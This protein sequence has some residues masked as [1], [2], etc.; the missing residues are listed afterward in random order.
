MTRVGAL[1]T[2]LAVGALA[3]CTGTGSGPKDPISSTP[4]GSASIVMRDRSN[5]AAIVPSGNAWLLLG[6]ADGWRTVHSITPA[7]VPTGGGLALDDRT[8]LTAVGVGPY[9]RLV[10]SPVLTS[11]DPANGWTPTELPAGLA[12]SQHAVAVDVDAVTAVTATAGGTLLRLTKGQWQQVT[13]A[14]DLDATH[15]LVLDS[16]VWA[17][18]GTGWLTGHATGGAPVAFG[19]HDD[20]RSWT[21]VGSAPA[22]AVSALA[23]CGS[24]NDWQLPFLGADL[25]I[26]VS[27]ST[28]LGR[29]WKLGAAIPTGSRTPAWTCRGT[30]SWLLQAADG[31][32]S[33][34]TSD[35]AGTTWVSTGSAPSDVTGLAMTG[36]DTGYAVGK[37]TSG[38]E[39]WTVTSSAPPRFVPVALPPW[40]ATIGGAQTGR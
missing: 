9:D 36:P 38:A 40:V 16:I 25:S 30:S 7:A 15:R 13:S 31:G 39:L 3:A 2:I 20:G 26:R 5:G 14:A 12:D 23:P 17:T 34:W 27:R 18:Q 4:R 22:G 6:T 24:G 32:R 35:D 21:A 1:C 8:N 29:S 10:A 28:D 33:L 19:T 37:G 11:E